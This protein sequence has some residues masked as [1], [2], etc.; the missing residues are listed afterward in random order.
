LGR[1]AFDERRAK[2]KERKADTGGMGKE[3]VRSRLGWRDLPVM[4]PIFFLDIFRWI[5]ENDSALRFEHISY[6]FRQA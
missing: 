1:I 3:P 2:H 5:T 4:I 6:V